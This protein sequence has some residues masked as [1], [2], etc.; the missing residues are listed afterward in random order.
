MGLQLFGVFELGGS[1]SRLGSVGRHG[2]R[3]GGRGGAA[4]FLMGLFATA[5]ATPCTA[6]FMGV[7]LSFA[8]SHNAVSAFGVFTSMALGLAAP[9]FAI[10]ASPGLVR[11]LPES[12]AWT[13]TFRRLLGFPMM[14]AVV[15]LA[16]VLAG[17]RGG[18]AFPGLLASLLAAA[19]GAWIWAHGEA[20]SVDGPFGYRPP[21]E[22]SA[23]WR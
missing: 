20:W 21:R 10:S 2:L 1:L 19:L 14:A 16:Y 18:A 5:V 13:A 22:R 4:S 17:Q 6:P 9:V 12:G 11:V 7:A 3:S 23:F 8:L 15:W